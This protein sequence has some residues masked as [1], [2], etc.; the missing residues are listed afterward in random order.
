MA[1]YVVIRR[2]EVVEGTR[3]VLAVAVDD[4][5]ELAVLGDSL[6]ADDLVRRSGDA[7]GDTPEE[8]MASLLTGYSHY[9][10]DG[11][12]PLDGT[13][14]STLPVLASLYGL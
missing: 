9:H 11:P 13:L 1:S 7:V 14:R 10:L 6:I 3:E 12:V 2:A 8:R 5:E 4:G